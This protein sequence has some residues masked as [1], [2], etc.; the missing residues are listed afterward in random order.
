MATLQNSGW[1]LW[2]T[3][4]VVCGCH[5]DRRSQGQRASPIVFEESFDGADLARFLGRWS[6]ETSM[7]PSEL[8]TAPGRHGS[9]LRVRAGRSPEQAVQLSRAID[10][11]ALRG[12]RVRVSLWTKA[13]APSQSGG[14]LRL[15]L[16]RSN[17]SASTWDHETSRFAYTPSW[18]SATAVIDVPSEAV[19]LRLSIIINGPVD[20][21][22][23]DLTVESDDVRP[24]AAQPLTAI[25]QARL[26]SLILA[27]GYVRFF[28]PGDAAARADWQNIEIEAVGRILA[29]DDSEAVKAELSKLVQRIAPDAALYSGL[30]P[31]DIR[32]PPPPHAAQLTRWIHDG[33]GS[34][35]P[36]G[37]SRTG[38][39]EPS[40]SG[41]HILVRKPLADIGPCKRAAVQAAV[42]ERTGQSLLQ[43]EVVPL[44]GRNRTAVT[45]AVDSPQSSVS[46]DISPDAYG[47]AFGVFVH[48]LGTID[49]ANVTLRCDGRVASEMRPDSTFD[50]SGALRYLYTVSSA[51]DCGLKGCLRIER[52][53]ETTVQA[54]DIVD[55]DI[56]NDL[57]LRMPVVAWTDGSR[58]L[59]VRDR[60][61]PEIRAPS[62]DRP[63]RIA[64]VL[65]LWVVLRWFYPY[66]EDQHTNWDAALGP[67]L[68]DAATATSDDE[69]RHALSRLTWALRDDHARVLRPGIDDGLLPI[70]FRSLEDR[71]I[72]VATLPASSSIPIGSTLV[73][74]DG[75]PAEEARRRAAKLMSAATPA[76]GLRHST[77]GIAFGRKGT[78]ATLTIRE[79]GSTRDTVRIVTRLDRGGLVPK[80]R[81]ERPASGTLLADHVVYV[82]LHTLDE[83]TWASILPRLSDARAI[84]FDLR[85]YVSGASFVPLEYL[86]DRELRSPT[87]Q[88][89]LV[90]ASNSRRYEE[91]MWYIAPRRQRLQAKAIFLVDART[92]S[93]PETI[94]QIVRGEHLG[95]I[96]GEPSGGTNGTAA[97]Y[98]LIG[99]MSVRFT[100]MRVLN[101]DGSVFQGQGITPDIVVHPTIKGIISRRDEVLD[102]AVEFAK[103]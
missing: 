53:P 7:V 30:S 90:T 1:M 22:I 81:E 66:F 18:S 68:Q 87:W 85:G 89:P 17:S 27:L 95:T 44:V 34:S 58:T 46:T 100:A 83:V 10:A 39:D 2:L 47:V 8:D 23:D 15:E 96:I 62:S 70:L 33:F 21:T 63:A 36:Y 6:N 28:Y 92:A 3:A 84:I 42:L 76:F 19:S 74:I 54:T 31:P 77:Y 41:L 48:G 80:L 40:G 78:F 52:K 69:Q 32:I 16:A 65:D 29:L 35:A 26:R 14:D 61:A 93:A 75:I 24:V 11:S 43:V 4:L 102:A 60:I 94:L 20:L 12:R 82:D 59:P 38:I 99:G 88:L 5:A 50:T 73:A 71:I 55:V 9:G 25:Q 97:D 37:S 91:H 64:A 51:R 72:V 103:Q 56:G 86:T 98:D 101:H 79:P 49:I 13:A 67:A 57:R 45:A